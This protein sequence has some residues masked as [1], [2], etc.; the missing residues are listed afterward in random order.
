M[1]E[2]NIFIREFNMDDNKKEATKHLVESIKLT[3]TLSSVF[4]AGVIAF[5]TDVEDLGVF[6][7]IALGFYF[8]TLCL[9]IFCI[10][11]IVNKTWKDDGNLIS[12]KDLSTPWWIMM[13]AMIVAFIFMCVFIF[14]SNKKANDTELYLKAENIEL[15]YNQSYDIEYS[16]DSIGTIQ[17]NVKSYNHR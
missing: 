9:S 16:R 4:G 15:K 10:N 17:L 8:I 5:A 7:W 6:F 2:I 12:A 11:T 1:P 13:V 14:T 3:F